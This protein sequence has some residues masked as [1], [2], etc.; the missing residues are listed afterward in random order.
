MLTRVILWLKR[1]PFDDPRKVS[2]Y[3]R[4]AHTVTTHLMDARRVLDMG[5]GERLFSSL[6]RSDL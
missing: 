5:C 1:S 3:E 6:I 2:R 4:L